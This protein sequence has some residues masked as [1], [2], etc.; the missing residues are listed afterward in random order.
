MFKKNTKNPVY[1]KISKN[2]VEGSNPKR[3]IY[4]WIYEKCTSVFSPL[5]IPRDASSMAEMLK[6]ITN[7]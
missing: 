3:N 6:G 2:Q 1:Q 5:K 4:N 7:W